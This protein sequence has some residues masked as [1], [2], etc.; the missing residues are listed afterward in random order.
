MKLCIFPSDPI[1]DI[2]RKGE[3]KPGYLNPENIFD[4]IYIIN[5]S[6]NKVEIDLIQK[7]AGT[8]KIIIHPIGKINLI[9]LLKE[10]KSILNLVKIVA[11]DVI[12]SYNPLIQGYLAAYCSNKLKIPFYLSLHADYK[13]EIEL[14]YKRSNQKMKYLKLLLTR[15]IT[16]K[17]SITSADVVTCA[18]RS[19]IP[20]AKKSGAKRIEVVYNR[21]DLQQFNKN[22]KPAM[23]LEKPIILNVG[24]FRKIKNQECLIHA[25]KELD[26]FLVFIGRGEMLEEMRTLVKKLNIEKKVI[27]IEAVEHS[28]IQNYYASALIHAMP[29]KGSGIPIPALEGLASGCITVMAE[30]NREKDE[31]IDAFV[32][33]VKNDPQSFR[34]AFLE[35][36]DHID[37]YKN[38][39]LAAKEVLLKIS[40]EEME[41]KESGIYQSLIKTSKKGF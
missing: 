2:V 10:K 37:K 39:T 11:P 41:K 23:K 24:N 22:V 26:V 5:P 1:E 31:S 8:A 28:K 18:Y 6:H 27:F 15:M 21:V 9:N 25:I 33:Y 40:S 38:K 3:V 4:E 30:P 16:E 29:I 12:R 35:I 19:L 20:Y 32:T 7:M 14:E 13:N 17:K 34:S 36:L